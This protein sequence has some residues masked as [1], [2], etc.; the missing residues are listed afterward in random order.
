MI[1]IK[2]LSECSL[3]DAVHAWNK[4]FE[5]YYFNMTTTVD[6]FTRRMIL[7]GLS[8]TLSIVAYDED[9]P[10]GLILNGVR[11][12]DGKKVSWNGGT[13]VDPEYRGK[14]VGKL[15]MDEMLAIYE[16]EGIDVATLEA[17]KENDRAIKLYEKMG[18]KVVDNL[19]QLQHT[20]SLSE[21]AFSTETTFTYRRGIPIDASTVPFYKS[22]VP[23]QTQWNNA[24]DGESLVAVDESGEAVGY[25]I[26]KRHFNDEGKLV[27]L[28]LFQCEAAPEYEN[29]EAVVK[30][31]LH[32]VY[33]P[34]DIEV[35][36]SAG[37]ISATNEI[38]RKFLKIEGFE[39]K[40]E[41]VFM[42]K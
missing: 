8:P 38:L 26:Y 34:F 22:M 3:Q 42:I 35:L 29:K 16:E 41:Q 27:A 30:A 4:G 21:K 36:R 14:G 5:G 37:N 40:A 33:G 15:L 9:K 7:E 32:E 12:I 13:G 24:R 11:L 18:Y 31:L 2:R 1:T 19:V 20:G 23:W 10:V 39:V 6:L 25:A 17:I 28:I